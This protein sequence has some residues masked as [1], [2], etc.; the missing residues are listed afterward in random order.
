MNFSITI[1]KQTFTIF[2][3]LC[4]CGLAAQKQKKYDAIYSGIPWFD[5]KG[6]V[7]SAHGAN[8]V[9]EKNRYYLFGERHSDTS[10]AFAGFNCYSSVLERKIR[11]AFR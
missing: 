4:A 8:I 1:F 6:N 5:D 11:E 10:N 3:V 9:K 2:L 7:V